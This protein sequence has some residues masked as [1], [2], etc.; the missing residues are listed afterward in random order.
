[1]DNEHRC[2]PLIGVL[3]WVVLVPR[4]SV[5]PQVRAHV[6]LNQG[7]RVGAEH[8][9]DAE[10]A[11]VADDRFELFGKRLAGNPVHHISTVTGSQR[12]GTVGVDVLHRLLNVL[13]ASD[14]VVVGTTTPVAY[15][16]VDEGLPETCGSG[17]VGRDD[18][19]ALFGVD[20]GVPACAPRFFPRADG[21]TMDQERKGVGFVGGEV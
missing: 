8:A 17:G 10:Y 12:D 3:R 13:E 18:D 2:G 9:V 1:M 15:D 19:V 7:T 21:A 5:V 16:S 20:S 14:D 11:V 4:C 6:V